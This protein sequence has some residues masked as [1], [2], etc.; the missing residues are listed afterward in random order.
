MT[1]TLEQFRREMSHRG[2]DYAGPILADG[3]L[4][5]FKAKGDKARNSWFILFPDPPLAGAFGCWQQGLTG[6]WCEK[7]RER[8][9]DAGRKQLDERW[10]RADAEAAA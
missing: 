4:H 1:E 2:L 8:L 5:R 3:K 6:K 9:G 7:R 10:Q